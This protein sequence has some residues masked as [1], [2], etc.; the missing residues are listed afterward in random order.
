MFYVLIFSLLAVV[1]VVG[2]LSTMNRRRQS[3]GTDESQIGYDDEGRTT[4]GQ[5]GHTTHTDA[6]R[7]TRKA[8]RLQSRHGR[9]KRH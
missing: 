3:P 7:R 8:K 9:R 1:L 2:G 5:V 4:H 6:S